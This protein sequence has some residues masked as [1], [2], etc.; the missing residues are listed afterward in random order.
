MEKTSALNELNVAHQTIQA[1]LQGKTSEMENLLQ[2]SREVRDVC[3]YYGYVLL[4]TFNFMCIFN[5]GVIFIVIYT[6][7]VP[8]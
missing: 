2:Q 1:Q 6:T 5:V 3:N 4:L 7:L 8:D